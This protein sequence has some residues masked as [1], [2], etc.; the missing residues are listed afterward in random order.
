MHD[1]H[2]QLRVLLLQR[3]DEVNGLG[4]ERLWTRLKEAVVIAAAVSG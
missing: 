4:L 1:V 2:G 3:G